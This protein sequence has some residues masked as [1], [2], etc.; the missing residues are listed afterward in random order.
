MFLEQQSWLGGAQR[1]LEAALDSIAAE[2]DRLV[3]FPAQGPFRSSLEG[4][5]VE[6]MSL[7]LGNYRSGPKSWVEMGV[8]AFR[9]LYCGVK[10]AIVIRRRHI[11]LVYINGPRWLPAGVLASRLAGRPAIFHLHLI[12][13]RKSE[14]ILA[15]RLARHVSRIVACSSAAAAPLLAR[16]PDLAAKI[17]VV[18]NPAPRAGGQ[19]QGWGRSPANHFTIGTAGRI[20]KSKGHH[21]LIEA[22]SMLPAQLRRRI[23]VLIVG[24]PAP[25]SEED[26]GYGEVL[27]AE[28][29]RRGLEEQIVWSGYQ[30]DMDPWYASMDVLVHPS[31]AEAMSIVILE[32]LQHGI[33]VIAARTGGT[34]EVVRQ[35]F[36]GLL[37]DADDPGAL[38]E[39][40]ML[41]L[42]DR[43]LR[44]G[45][46]AGARIGLDRRFL[47][48]TFASRTRNAVAELCA[49][50]RQEEMPVSAARRTGG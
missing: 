36:N 38:A 25:G 8:F 16:D 7:P 29:T 5:R 44:E 32:A 42:N 45:L 9:S 20:T 50:E 46:Q 15:T 49:S 6:T 21:L 30:A 41:F 37:V 10:L 3:V 13:G 1:V 22:L 43:M 18:Y 34:P 27:R 11:G 4:K 14:L 17:D 2:C 40:L 28:V 47:P 35:G 12:L 24:S 31:L 48:E 19:R 23:Q 26:L 39:A 33:P